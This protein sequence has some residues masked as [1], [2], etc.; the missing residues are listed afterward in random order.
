VQGTFQG[1]Q[2]RDHRRQ[3]A[4]LGGGDHTGREGG[5]VEAV[6]DHR[7]EIG[8]EAPRLAILDGRVAQ[9]AQEVG[10]VAGGRIGSHRREVPGP[11]HRHGGRHRGSANGQ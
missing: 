1:A 11:S 9:H 10:R 4:R 5:C 6:V 7:H 2:S 3:K 8:V